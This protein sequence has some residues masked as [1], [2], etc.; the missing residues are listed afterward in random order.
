[1]GRQSEQ[2]LEETDLNAPEADSRFDGHIRGLFLHMGGVS[3][4]PHL[5]LSW[6]V[7]CLWQFLDD[8]LEQKKHGMK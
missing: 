5:Y 3:L 7:L 2:N 6:P 4:F 8:K 1:M